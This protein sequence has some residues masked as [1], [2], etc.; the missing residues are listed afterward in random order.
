MWTREQKQRKRERKGQKVKEKEKNPGK[1]AK[2]VH[3]ERPACPRKEDTEA[4]RRRISSRRQAERDGKAECPAT[5]SNRHLTRYW[6]SGVARE[7]LLK[8]ETIV[9]ALCT[10]QGHRRKSRARRETRLHSH[11]HVLV[12]KQL[13]ARPSV[14]SSAPVA[15]EQRRRPDDEGMQQ[16]THLARFGGRAAIPLTLLAQRTE[17]AI[18]DATGIHHTQAPIGFPAPLMGNQRLPGRATEGAIWLEGKVLT[19]EAASFP[20]QAHLRGSI[21]RSRGSVCWDRWE[22]WSKLGGTHRVRS[23][24]MTQLQEPRSRPIAR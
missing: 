10:G 18:A 14:L 5:Q 12:A 24:L 11:F 13:H 16:H 21:A 7:P 8:V 19:R 23:K 2:K 20:G 4:R 22:C 1:E 15:P 6:D 3:P 9:R 17:A